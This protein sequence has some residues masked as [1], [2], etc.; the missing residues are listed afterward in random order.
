MAGNVVSIH[1]RKGVVAS[2]E[3]LLEHAKNGDLSGIAVV[4]T[5][6]DGAVIEG[7]AGIEDSVVP[8]IGALRIL[9]RRVISALVDIPEETE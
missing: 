3:E 4:G 5:F 7:W 1:S 2:L 9:E 6:Q 8:T